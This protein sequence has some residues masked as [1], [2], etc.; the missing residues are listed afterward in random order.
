M[1]TNGALTDSHRQQRTKSPA[2]FRVFLV[3]N[4]FYF[5]RHRRDAWIAFLFFKCSNHLLLTWNARTAQIGLQ[6]CCALRWKDIIFERQTDRRWVMLS[7]VKRT[8]VIMLIANPAPF[9]S[10]LHGHHRSAYHYNRQPFPR[11]KKGFYLCRCAC[12]LPL[13]LNC[14]LPG[15]RRTH[16]APLNILC[17]RSVQCHAFLRCFKMKYYAVSWWLRFCI[18]RAKRQAQLKWISLRTQCTKQP[19][20]YMGMGGDVDTFIRFLCLVSLL[21]VELTTAKNTNLVRAWQ[22]QIKRKDRNMTSNRIIFAHPADAIRTTVDID[23]IQMRT[24]TALRLLKMDNKTDNL[25]SFS[26]NYIFICSDVGHFHS[27]RFVVIIRS[28]IH[29]AHTTLG[30]PS[31]VSWMRLLPL[32]SIFA[33]C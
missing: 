3:R 13:L 5:S 24:L 12:R 9:H 20:L 19:C 2:N 30:V 4:Y 31:S 33:E 15:E 25:A 22:R 21:P 8:V 1:T 18:C 17:W 7:Y 14:F 28:S 23:S 26:L 11:T 16:A 32:H 29:W 10:L 27:V 6:F